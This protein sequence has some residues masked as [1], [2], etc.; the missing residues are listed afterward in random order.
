M[1]D[2]VFNGCRPDEFMHAIK[3][4][5]AF[6]VIA[7][8]K[9]VSARAHWN[10]NRF[11]TIDTKLKED[12]LID[13]FCN[14]YRPMPLVSPW[15]KSSGFYKEGDTASKIEQS[16]DLRLEPYREVV[17]AARDVVQNVLG[18][19]YN[20]ML[21]R[22]EKPKN[23]REAI[24]RRFG[25]KKD[26]MV[27]EL[28]NRLPETRTMSCL[29]PRSVLSWLDTAWA[30]KASKNMT[31]G[32]ALLTGGND[33]RF[34]MSVNF[35]ET[36]LKHVAG[37]NAKKEA[38]LVRNALFGIT[39]DAKFEEI[40]VGTYMPGAYMS[41]AVNS[42]G[43]DKY[44]L[45]NPWDYMLAMEGIVLFAGSIYR[46]GEFKFA[47]FPFSVKLSHAGYGTAATETNKNEKGKGEIW[48][49]I[50]N[51]PAT[52]DEIAYVFAEGRVQ[53]SAKKPSS[54]ADFAVALAGFGAMRGISAFQ[55]FG[56]FERK[57]QACHIT[58]VGT[59]HTAQGIMGAGAPLSEIMWSEVDAW[60]DNIRN[61][62]DNLPKSMSMLLRMIDDRIIRYCEHKKSAY[63]LDILVTIGKI[64]RQIALSPKLNVLPLKGLS[65]GWLRKCGYGTPEFRLAAALGSVYSH[66]NNGDFYP[67][68]YNLEP[69]RLDKAE[70][71]WTS[72][73][74]SV[75]WGRGSLVQNMITALER[76]Y[77]DRLVGNKRIAIKSHIYSRIDD[78]VKFIEGRV[79]DGIIYD[80]V[81]PLSMIDYR[82]M[83][84]SMMPDD[85]RVDYDSVPESYTCLK[86]NF[87]P[88]MRQDAGGRAGAFEPSVIGLLKAG[89]QIEALSIMRRRLN[90]SGYRIVTYGSASELD[91]QDRTT[92]LR[93]CA[94][95][96]FPLYTR[97]MTKLLK[98]L[99]HY[100]NA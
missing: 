1:S 49:P 18:P 92:V 7:E 42:I 80:L 27:S 10:N 76:R 84:E 24:E 59:I 34:E 93:M 20:E 62:K 29:R 6:S 60:L 50:W 53:S 54:G 81:L 79:N 72:A 33:G 71:K 39:T 88:V 66:N 21:K 67:I 97:D 96:F 45:C 19:I 25:E 100:D 70:L 5:G 44:T 40:K 68:R 87:P 4:L 8:Q 35:M 46:R 63:L 83:D 23:E 65:S 94:A 2:I 22:G 56:V 55:R 14:D 64:E 89:R 85:V 12:E 26:A 16:A 3:A 74:P 17:R 31:P 91:E 69:V 86:S 38:K 82:N 95:L 52:Y 99:R 37:G 47:S 61:N 43:D 75:T 36:V 13:F 77:Y 78:V 58:S 9:D 57:G 51:S 15:N 48:M 90:I 73:S 11:F 41:P 28:R 32:P 30:I 98:R